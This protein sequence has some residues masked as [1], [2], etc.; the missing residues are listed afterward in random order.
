MAV[1]IDAD[2]DI[3]GMFLVAVNS[4]RDENGRD[5]LIPEAGNRRAHTRGHIPRSGLVQLESP[6]QQTRDDR[7]ETDIGQPEPIR[8]SDVPAAA[9]HGLEE[10]IRYRPTQ[11]FAQHAADD[12]GNKLQADLLRIEVEFLAEGDGHL[13]DEGDVAVAE[14]DGVGTRG[15]HHP[16]EPAEEQGLDELAHLQGARISASWDEPAEEALSRCGRRVIIDNIYGLLSQKDVRNELDEVNDDEDPEDP[17][18]AD[19]VRDKTHDKWPAGGSKCQHQCPPADL[20]RAFLGLTEL[21]DYSTADA[22]RWR[23]EDAREHS[24]HH[25]AAIR[26][27]AG[28]SDVADE[29][30]KDGQQEY[31]VSAVDGGDGFP[32]E[33]RYSQQQDLGAQ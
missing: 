5:D 10:P 6:S 22:N 30:S 17:L 3:G 4:K 26:G 13:D 25:L 20:L 7:P 27:A 28:A 12:D 23:D 11:L 33:R 8:G 15:D 16:G 2:P 31:M 14:N 21:R 32:D 9:A 18:V 24:S 1:D 19:V 29:T